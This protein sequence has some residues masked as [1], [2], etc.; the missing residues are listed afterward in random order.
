[1]TQRGFSLVE[2]LVALAISMIVSAALA[3]M[4]PPARV[5]FEHTPAALDAQQ[6]HRTTTDAL[7]QAVR[8]A[9]IP[10]FVPPVVLADPDPDGVRF[11]TLLAITPRWNGARGIL[12]IDQEG[13][14]G[15]LMLAASPCPGVLEVCGFTRGTTTV[16]ADGAGHF[17]LFEV[18]STNQAAGS[19]VAANAFTTSYPAG[20]IVV[21]VDAYTL[22]LDAR[23]DGAHALV[24]E[25]I[26]GATQ[27]IVDRVR[28]MWFELSGSRLDVQVLLDRATLHTAVFLRNAS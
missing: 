24:R 27:P 18:A 4:V 19:L 25:T 15:A 13:E 9:G 5:A 1:M 8:A 23:P 2:L 11:A 7:T 21:E 3:A 17:D 28:A 14:S 20:S 22:R 6:R 12:A 26:A 16:I 10:G